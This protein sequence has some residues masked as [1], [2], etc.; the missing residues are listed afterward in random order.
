M[1]EKEHRHMSE[2]ETG[3]CMHRWGGDIIAKRIKG[4]RKY[5]TQ[6]TGG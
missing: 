3:K 2:N 5:V 6:F 1:D 4:R